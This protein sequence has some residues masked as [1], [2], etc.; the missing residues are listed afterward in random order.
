FPGTPSP[1]FPVRAFPIP[2]AAAVG[3]A[4]AKPDPDPDADTADAS[5]DPRTVRPPSRKGGAWIARVL[6]PAPARRSPGHGRVVGRVN[7]TISGGDGRTTELLVLAWKSTDRGRKNWLKVRLTARPNDLAG[8]IPS[9]AVRLKRNI[10]WVD[11]RTS[12][13]TV[14][15]YRRGRL[16]RTIHAV[17]GAPATPT[18][19]GLFAVSFA[20]AQRD[21][22]GFIGPWA[23]HLSAHSEVLEDYG[24]GPGRVAIHGRGGAS[25]NDPLGTARS[26]GCVRVDN[27]AVRWLVDRLRPG[28]PVQIRL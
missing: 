11:V 3:A 13:R 5:V 9:T 26:H 6:T 23:I 27:E 22:N 12:T 25:L 19:R 21:P 24:G 16:R 10:W 14:R 8:W 4:A 1:A 18:P 17:V 7:R 2:A 15:V 20:A 28:T